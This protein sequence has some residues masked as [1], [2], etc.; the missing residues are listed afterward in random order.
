MQHAASH[1]GFPG[2]VVMTCVTMATGKSIL[3]LSFEYSNVCVCVCVCV[4][5]IYLH[6]Y[7]LVIY[8]VF[9]FTGYKAKQYRITRLE[10]IRTGLFF[11]FEAM[12]SKDPP[13]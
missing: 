13:C 7:C 11:I 2:L 3:C 9:I 6:L 10:D 4:C 8:V 12:K 5:V 1:G